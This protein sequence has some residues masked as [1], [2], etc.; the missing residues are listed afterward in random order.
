MNSTGRALLILLRLRLKLLARGRATGGGRTGRNPRN[1]LLLRTL[2]LI[3]VAIIFATSIGNVLSSVVSGPTGRLVLAPL[4][5]WVSTWAT[6]LLFLFAV[7]TV[8]ATFTYSSDLRL[9]LLTPLSPRLLLGEKFILVYSGFAL[10]VVVVGGIVLIGVGQALG[11]GPG[12][13]LVTLLTLL[14]L[15]IGPLAVAMLLTVLVLRWVPPARA[16]NVTAVLGALIGIS[17]YIGSQIL[18]MRSGRSLGG[19]Q[20][21]VAQ[22][23]HAWWSNLPT[24]WPGQALAAAGQGEIATAVTYLL[25]AAA[26]AFVLAAPAIVLSAH[27]FATGWASYQEVGR[28][29]RPAQITPVATPGAQARIPRLADVP[30]TARP[31]GTGGRG[32]YPVW[33]PLVG[34]EWRT[35]VRDP[36]LWARLL[37]P[38][39]AVI[40]G[41]YRTF[42]QNVT[43]SDLANGGSSSLAGIGWLFGTLAFMTYIVVAALSLPVINREGRALYLLALAPLSARDILLAKWTFCV[44][45]IL[46]LVEGALLVSSLVLHLP[47][48]AAL[49]GALALAALVVALSGG[50]LLLSLLW[51]RL[52]W[53]NP[54]QQVSGTANLAGLLCGL[55][56]VA[57]T[58]ALLILTL[59]WS[60]SQPLAATATGLGIFALTGLVIASVA[61]LAPRRLAALLMR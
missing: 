15:P 1:T 21:T 27:L 16:R 17:F 18:A 31:A 59:A 53:D 51:P 46:A 22:S 56:L 38:L 10:P 32:R 43:T 23:S 61:V 26:L 49:L 14:L 40:F 37:Y 28:R 9:L 47:L 39:A 29:A 60:S 52:D 7:P 5:I 44:L 24:T 35:L 30:A 33:W 58:G 20:V 11:E 8:L 50:E 54:R 19:L 42:T 13:D 3:V 55:V 57:A 2:V 4:L 34:K 12:Y 25:A 48:G 36:S 41:F 6:V 45:P